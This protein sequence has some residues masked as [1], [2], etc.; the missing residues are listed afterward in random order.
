MC[1][2]TLGHLTPLLT[3]AECII[4]LQS[5]GATTLTVP[6]LLVPVLAYLVVVTWRAVRVYCTKGSDGLKPRTRV[7][8][9]GTPHVNLASILLNPGVLCICLPSCVAALLPRIVILL[10]WLVVGRRP[11]VSL[12][13]DLVCILSLLVW[14]VSAQSLHWIFHVSSRCCLSLRRFTALRN[15]YIY[16]VGAFSRLVYRACVRSFACLVRVA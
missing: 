5:L 16:H 11:P 7:H 8:E 14:C 15:S 6:T 12:W 4:P 1:M 9:V 10:C 2:L 13:Q 3:H